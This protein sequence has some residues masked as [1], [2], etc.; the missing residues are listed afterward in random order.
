[1]TALPTTRRLVE[2][3]YRHHHVHLQQ[4][5]LCCGNAPG[6]SE[7]RHFTVLLFRLR[8][9]RTPPLPRL[10]FRHR[11]HHPSAG[12]DI[13]SP[14]PLPHACIPLPVMPT[15]DLAPQGLAPGGRSVKMSVFSWLSPMYALLLL[16]WVSSVLA[17]RPS[18][19]EVMRQET[20]DMFYHGFDN[21]MQ[22]AFPEDEVRDHFNMN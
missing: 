12:F 11:C 4:N 9:H 14:C 5:A 8:H 3:W 16:S 6:P 18:R 13:E 10:R 7:P 21:Y 2:S 20:I 15:A 19:I 22:V 17:M 1:M